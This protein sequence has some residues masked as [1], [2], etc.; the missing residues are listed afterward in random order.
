MKRQQMILDS[1]KQNLF[2]QW[3][4]RTNLGGECKLGSFSVQR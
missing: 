3:S 1:K 2:G 4:D